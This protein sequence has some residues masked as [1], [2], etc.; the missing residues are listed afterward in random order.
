MAQTFTIDARPHSLGDLMMLTGTFT[1]AG[2]SA[3]GDITLPDHFSK[4]LAAGH[5]G[6]AASA[7]VVT[8]EIDATVGT[9]V[10]IVCGANVG[11]SWWA[12][13]TR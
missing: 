13:G 8:T 1:N 2:G 3:G 11:G 9:T 7:P 6:N 4:I 12:I 5:N 10:T